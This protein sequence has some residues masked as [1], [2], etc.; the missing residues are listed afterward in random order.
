M[1]GK[2]IGG[3]G[4]E[5]ARRMIQTR[6]GGYFVTGTTD[7]EGQGSSDMLCVK[8]DGAG[9]VEWMKTVGTTQP[10]PIYGVVELQAGGYVLAGSNMVLGVIVSAIVKLDASG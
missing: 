9:D 1:W 3:V 10:D 6:D 8:L 7:S 4:F 2:E 5:Y